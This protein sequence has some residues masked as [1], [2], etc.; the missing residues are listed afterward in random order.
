MDNAHHSEYVIVIPDQRTEDYLKEIYFPFANYHGYIVKDEEQRIAGR[1]R[2]DKN[3]GTQAK[4]ERVDSLRAGGMSLN[5]A[6]D[7]VG[8]GKG[9]YYNY[10][11]L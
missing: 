3:K 2:G 6:V 1:K 9:T 10:K 8:I 11:K 5:K 4:V 7:V